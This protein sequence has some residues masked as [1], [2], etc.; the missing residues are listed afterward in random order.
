M[1]GGCN[2]LRIMGSVLVIILQAHVLTIGLRNLLLA[3]YV[4]LNYPELAHFDD[5]DVG[6]TV[7]FRASPPCGSRPWAHHFILPTLECDGK[8]G[9]I[10]KQSLGTVTLWQR[11]FVLLRH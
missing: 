2:L 11:F 9:V 7:G 3:G 10:I 8:S 1:L 4:G 5:G 6:P